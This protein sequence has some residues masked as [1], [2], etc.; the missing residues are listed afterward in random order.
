MVGKLSETGVIM[1]QGAGKYDSLCTGVR[2]ASSAE[3]VVLIVINGYEG[4]GFSV[5]GPEIV[6]S[7]LPDMLEEMA[8]EIRRDLTAK[9]GPL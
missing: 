6:L 9:R 7:T 1:T 2:I 4:S 5:Q 8:K 3:G